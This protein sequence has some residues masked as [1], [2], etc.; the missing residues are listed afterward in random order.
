MISLRRSLALLP[1]LL[2][3]LF[4]CKAEPASV[5]SLAPSLGLTG[6]AAKTVSSLA[7]QVSPSNVSPAQRAT[8]A[9]KVSRI[10]FGSALGGNK[11]PQYL[12]HDSQQYINRTEINWSTSCWKESQCILS[13]SSAQGVSRAMLIVNFFDS[14][15]ATR[16]GGHSTNIGYANV[17]D[18]GILIDVVNLDQITYNKKTITFGS[19]QRWG[20]VYD[21]LKD[22]S[23]IAIGGRSPR[24]GVG[25]LMVGGGM[26]YFSSLYGIVSDGNQEYEVVLANSSIV[27][28]NPQQNPDLFKALKGG[29]SNFG[30][31]TKFS[32]DAIPST[33]LWFE[34]RTYNPD[35]TPE[36][37]KALIQYQAASENDINANLV[38]SVGNTA[39]L[40]GF[41]Y[42]KPVK[43]PA[44]YNAFYNIP[45]NASFI[46]STIG[47]PQALVR[48]FS[49]VG[50]T[51][52]ARYN[53]CTATFKPD[54][55]TYEQS[56]AKWLAI[57]TKAAQDFGAIM[58]Y[59]VQPFT[60]AAA[61]HGDTRGGNVL[62]LDKVGQS[63]FAGTVQWNSPNDDVA[64]Q[65]T[66]LSVCGAVKDA[67]TANGAHLPFLFMN[68]ANYAQ[69]VLGSYGSASKAQL[70]ATARKYDPQGVFQRLQNDGFLLRKSA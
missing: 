48:A 17:D 42:A 33:D 30:I 55:N 61:K 16:S 70:R 35:Q 68:D 41:V 10:V 40:V 51:V 31:I 63:W 18:Y 34:A 25:G 15:F 67:A 38:F 49:S 4:C 64:A 39:T 21:Y 46:D 8:L 5:D 2:L 57:S 32:V 13:P 27:R 6:D 37:F 65:Q 9:C 47:Q 26:P 19:G 45:F 44:V 7:A 23:V 11:V 43:R 62:G 36:L 22:T 52:V 12:D 1:F 28:A 56:Y 69:D 29:G 50:G 58:T 20:Q 53:T 66:L 60:S 54:I 24:V 14:K 3:V 59:G